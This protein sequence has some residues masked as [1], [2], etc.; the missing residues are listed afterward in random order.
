MPS[1]WM[2]APSTISPTFTPI[3]N[4]I[5]LSDAISEFRLAIARWISTAQRKAS[6]ALTNRTSKPSPVVLTIRPR[7]SLILGFNELSMVSVQSGQRAFVIDANQ[8]AVAG[9]IRHQDCHES[10]FNF[11]TGHSWYSTAA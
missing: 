8:A 2:L 1:P 5:R 3:L 7:C 6:T 9:Y 4:S 11:F 10:A